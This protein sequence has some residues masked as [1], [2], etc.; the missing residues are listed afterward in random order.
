MKIDKKDKKNNLK[1]DGIFKESLN[2]TN[3]PLSTLENLFEKLIKE[4]LKK[5][6]AEYNERT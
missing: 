3:R 5:F 1:I 2:E 6:H 4:R